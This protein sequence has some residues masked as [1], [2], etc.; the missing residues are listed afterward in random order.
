MKLPYDTYLHYIRYNYVL[1]ARW[2]LLARWFL[3]TLIYV[4]FVITTYQ[5][6]HLLLPV[7]LSS[8]FH[9]NRKLFGI[10]IELWFSFESKIVWYV[11]VNENENSSVCAGMVRSGSDWFWL[12]VRTQVTSCS[13]GDRAFPLG[14]V[15]QFKMYFFV[16][17][18]FRTYYFIITYLLL[19]FSI[20]FGSPS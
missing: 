9:S 18:Y 16:R 1:L 5:P 17:T 20:F 12:M 15:L 7:W 10:L 11:H 6:M 2:L 8:D 3:T 4:I 19:L 13:P 14:C